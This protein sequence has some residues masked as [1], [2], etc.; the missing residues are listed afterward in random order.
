VIRTGSEPSFERLAASE[1]EPSGS[2]GG[3]GR[4]APRQMRAHRSSVELQPAAEE[5]GEA[6]GVDAAAGPRG[7]A[8]P[9]WHTTLQV[10]SRDWGHITPSSESLGSLLLSGL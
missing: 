9:R 10:S 2:G 6:E 7:S 5:E 8:D 4:P 1:A 3:G